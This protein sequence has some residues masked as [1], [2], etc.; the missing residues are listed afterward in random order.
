M[1][2]YDLEDVDGTRPDWGAV[3]LAARRLTLTSGMPAPA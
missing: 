3:D 2:E 1:R